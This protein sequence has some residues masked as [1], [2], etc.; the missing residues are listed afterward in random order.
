VKEGKKGEHNLY[1]N[2]PIN[3]NKDK[4]DECNGDLVRL[5]TTLGKPTVKINYIYKDMY[6]VC[7]CGKCGRYVRVLDHETKIGN[8]VV[9]LDNRSHPNK[10][11]KL[12]ER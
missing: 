4:C 6:W 12:R 11:H 8:N 10:I 3:T 7:V 2:L 9:T 5:H 1:N